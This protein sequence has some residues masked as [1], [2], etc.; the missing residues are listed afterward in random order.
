MD[1]IKRNW[2]KILLRPKDNKWGNFSA[3]SFPFSSTLR[4]NGFSCLLFLS[5]RTYIVSCVYHIH[6]QSVL[7]TVNIYSFFSSPFFSPPIEKLFSFL[8][9]FFLFFLSS[10]K[11]Y[12]YFRFF[13]CCFHFGFPL[14]DYFCSILSTFSIE[15]KK[16]K[17]K[18]KISFGFD[19]IHKLCQWNKKWKW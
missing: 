4:M 9:F 10:P 17:E 16:R 7:T 1:H 5:S 6:T 3:E 12:F 15:S 14:H 13:F 18:L 19:M 2:K 8:Y 11:F